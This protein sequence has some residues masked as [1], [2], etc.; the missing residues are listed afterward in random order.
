MLTVGLYIANE[1]MIAKNFCVVEYLLVMSLSCYKKKQSRWPSW[2]KVPVSGTG[3]KGHGF[4]SH[5]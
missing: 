2:S 4:K 5:S 3:P 1:S